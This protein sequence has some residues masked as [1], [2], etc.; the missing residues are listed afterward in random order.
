MRQQ[1]V[2]DFL[3]Y[4]IRIGCPL[5]INIIRILIYLIGFEIYDF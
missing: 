2:S 4:S 3:K 5:E 1:V